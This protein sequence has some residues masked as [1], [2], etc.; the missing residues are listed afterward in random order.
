ML[1]KLTSIIM[2]LVLI[3][4]TAGTVL[5]A[6]TEVS[7][8]A[9]TISDYMD[10]DAIEFMQKMT[11]VYNYF[12]LNED[13]ILTVSKT[14][15]EIQSIADFSD[16]EMLLY[17]EMLQYNQSHPASTN[18]GTP[19]VSPRITVED[20]KIYFTYEEVQMYLSAAAAIGP[21]A[22]TAALTALTTVVSPG[23]GTV[24]GAIIG[25]VVS[26]DLCYLVI[27]A[28]L[29]QQGIYIGIDWNGIFPNYTQG[30]W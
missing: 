2:S 25:Y 18:P 28:G 16:A 21:A 24:L 13:G 8:I 6:D 7:N 4:S 23:V 22:M 27:Q 14:E 29:N 12:S 3:V 11:S 10:D 1:K 5:A 15:E 19:S 9:Y 17:N 20:W 26:A 30:T